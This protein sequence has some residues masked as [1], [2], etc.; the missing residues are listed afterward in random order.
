MFAAPTWKWLSDPYTLAKG[1]LVAALAY[2][3]FFIILPS[4][5][6]TWEEAHTVSTLDITPTMRARLVETLADKVAQRY[7]D[8]K[9]GVQVAAAI[10][11]AAR[12]GEYDGIS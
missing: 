5:L 11:Q 4:T 12:N 8:E 3:T 9:K 10:R 1:V 6:S 7:L 2:L